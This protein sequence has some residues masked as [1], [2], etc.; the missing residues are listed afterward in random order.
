M[1]FVG[2]RLLCFFSLTETSDVPKSSS[3]PCQQPSSYVPTYS[4][5][6]SNSSGSPFP[7]ISSPLSFFARA[8]SIESIQ[9]KLNREFPVREDKP[10]N[11]DLDKSVNSLIQD[12]YTEVDEREMKNIMLKE[13]NAILE[14]HQVGDS[15]SSSPFDK[16]QSDPDRTKVKSAKD[17][18]TLSSDGEDTEYTAADPTWFFED[19]FPIDDVMTGDEKENDMSS[20]CSLLDSTIFDP[21]SDDGN[22]S[23]EGT[24]SPPRKTSSPSRMLLTNQKKASTKYWMLFNFEYNLD[25]GKKFKAS[26]LEEIIPLVTSEDFPKHKDGK[27]KISCPSGW[28]LVKRKNPPTKA[29]PPLAEEKKNRKNSWFIT[30]TNLFSNFNQQKHVSTSDASAVCSDEDE[31]LALVGY[32]PWSYVWPEFKRTDPLSFSA[33]KLKIMTSSEKTGTFVPSNAWLPP[34]LK[35]GFSPPTI[36]SF[37]CAPLNVP[38]MPLPRPPVPVH[39]IKDG[40]EGW[41]IYDYDIEDKVT[42]TFR[43]GLQ[44][45]FLQSIKILKHSLRYGRIPET[46]SAFSQNLPSSNRMLSSTPPSASHHRPHA[47]RYATS[48]HRNFPHPPSH[49]YS[50]FGKDQLRISKPSSHIPTSQ[51]LLLDTP[52]PPQSNRPLLHLETNGSQRH[53]PPLTRRSS[54]R[55]STSRSDRIENDGVDMEGS[56]VQSGGQLIPLKRREVSRTGPK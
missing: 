11:F 47:M 46:S 30:S 20:S 29:P 39:S 6:S 16:K 23:D 7:S 49:Q 28:L 5:P 1:L 13:K 24:E 56:P 2:L 50:P 10:F 33:S 48:Y 26:A 40:H 34:H 19:Q 32:V 25:N 15:R 51:I 37:Y 3:F 42:F 21:I 27:T 8:L 43:V 14:R 44:G 9:D 4:S 52:S 45:N 55:S 22:T 53:N 18:V 36:H 31:S 17:V 41:T 35:K 38:S 12:E 54:S